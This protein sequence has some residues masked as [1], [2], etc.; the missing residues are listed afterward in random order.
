MVEKLSIIDDEEIN[1]RTNTADIKATLI[2][3]VVGAAPLVGPIISE[4]LVSFIPNQKI[5]RVIV[6]IECL[7]IKLRHLEADVLKQK[8]LTEEFTDLF[9]DAANQATRAI[10]NDR[11]EYLASLLKNGITGDALTHIDK[12]KMLSILGELNDAEVLILKCH[13]LIGKR[14]AEFAG[15]HPS[16]FLAQPATLRSGRDEIDRATVRETYTANLVRLGLLRNSYRTLRK[17]E[18][19]EFDDRTGLPKSTGY[20]VTALGRLLLWQLDILESEWR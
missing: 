13:T 4:A 15:Q 18:V 14:Q 2:R 20:D 19:P 6:F 5:N 10:S 17:G 9:E 3:G 7:D 16:L 12:K 8:M 11:R 1:L